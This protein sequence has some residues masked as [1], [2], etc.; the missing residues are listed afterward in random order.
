M[1]RDA[2]ISNALF[3]PQR[4]STTMTMTTITKALAL[5]IASVVLTSGAAA[6]ANVSGSAFGALVKTALVTTQSPLATLP[7]GGGMNQGSALSFGVPN[8][9]SSSWLM[10]ITTGAANNTASSAQSTSEVESVNLLGGVITADNVTAIASSYVNQSGRA[11]DASGSG[12]ANLVVNGVAISATP[13]PNTRLALPGLG[14]VVLNE[15]IPSGDGVTSS[16]MTVNMIH[17]VLQ[18]ALTGIQTG[19]VIVGSATSAVK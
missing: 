14:Y 16:G 13:A 7:A 15:Q 11:S 3:A 18:N 2:Q 19:E 4:G 17:V 10:S 1:N 6:Q 8:T 5:T 9:L 12:F